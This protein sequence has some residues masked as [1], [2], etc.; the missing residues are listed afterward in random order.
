MSDLFQQ[1]SPLV[2]IEFSEPKGAAPRIEEKP[3][4]GYLNLRGRSDHTGCSE[5]RRR[6]RPIP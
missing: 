2:Q 4:N 1:E 5:W 3:F 6:P